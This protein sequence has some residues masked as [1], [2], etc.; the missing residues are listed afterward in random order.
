MDVPTLLVYGSDDVRA[1]LDFAEVLRASIRR[2]S[3]V[4]I[5]GVGHVPNVEAP[6][7]FDAAVRTFLRSLA[8]SSSDE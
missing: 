8:S 4:V 2:S 3:L 7:A 1:R 6:E 5:E